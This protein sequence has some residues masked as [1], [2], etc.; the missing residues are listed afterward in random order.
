MKSEKVVHHP[1]GNGEIFSNVFIELEKKPAGPS[2]A[3]STDDAI[4]RWDGTG[5]RAQQNSLVTI[6]DSGN[7]NSPNDNAGIELGSRSASNTPFID[8][9]SSGNDIDWD[10][11]LIAS[12][13]TGSVGNG[14]LDVSAG[15]INWNGVKLATLNTNIWLQQQG[16]GTNALTDAATI[17]WNLQTQQVAKVTLGGNRTLDAPSNMVDGFTYILRVIQDGTG[18]R[19]LAYNA[20]FKWPGGVAPVL[21]TAANAID[22]LTF[23][24]DGT[25]MYG[26]A[27]KAFA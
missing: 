23:I 15:V 16:F 25:N 8:L 20:V 5:G 2:P 1:G 6:D 24:S 12:G 11:R 9:H 19:T 17:S 3:A 14:T 27:Q 22:I 10:V 7:Y 21:S 26:V 13:G 18:S 4:V